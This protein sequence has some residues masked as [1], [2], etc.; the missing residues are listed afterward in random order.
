MWLHKIV[1]MHCK[2]NLSAGHKLLRAWTSALCLGN[3]NKLL[4]ALNMGTQGYSEA[5]PLHHKWCLVFVYWHVFMCPWFRVKIVFF[6][7]QVAFL[8]I[9]VTRR[10]FPVNAAPKWS[11]RRSPTNVKNSG[12]FFNIQQIVMIPWCFDHPNISITSIHYYTLDCNKLQ[13]R[14]LVEAGVCHLSEAHDSRVEDAW[15]TA[16]T[17]TRSQ[18]CPR[19]G[20]CC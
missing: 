4:A 13:Q 8:C 2:C 17:Q 14:R 20:W 19:G 7:C 5:F 10:T 9:F 6:S 11:H 3:I 12:H 15:V 16:W 18:G 1:L